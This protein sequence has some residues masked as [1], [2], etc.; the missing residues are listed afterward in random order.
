V[1]VEDSRAVL[2]AAEASGRTQSELEASLKASRV[3]VS[4]DP[5][6]PA[7]PLTARILLTTLRRLPGQLVLD[8][9]GLPRALI[10]EL[11]NAVAAVDPTRAA[12]PRAHN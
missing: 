12:P 6:L 2:L 10:E 7:A 8:R 11:A 9:Q 5:D 1:P 3:I 4:L